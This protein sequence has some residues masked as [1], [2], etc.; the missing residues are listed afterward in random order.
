MNLLVLII[1]VLVLFTAIVL[2]PTLLW[3][4]VIAAWLRG[5]RPQVRTPALRPH[6]DRGRSAGDARR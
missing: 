3:V 1:G 6:R 5:P 4:A 2:I